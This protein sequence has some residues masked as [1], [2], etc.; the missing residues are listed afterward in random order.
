[1]SPDREIDLVLKA[2]LEDGPTGAPDRVLDALADRI[3]HESQRPGWRLHWRPTTM[4]P[5]FKV[6]VGIAAVLF[7]AIVGC[8]L[9]PASQ[10]GVGGPSA[11]P[12][13]TPT[14]SPT[15]TPIAM[16]DGP[17]AAGTYA[18]TLYSGPDSGGPFPKLVFTL[19]DG[20]TSSG[21]HITKEI[22]G[23]I[24]AHLIANAFQPTDEVYAHPCQWSSPARIQPGP[25]V[26]GLASALAAVPLRNATTP[27]DV[28]I[29][30]YHGKYL[31]WTVPNDIDFATCDKLDGEAV[32]QSWTG[33]NQQA[34]GQVDRLWILDIDGKRFV[35][36]AWFLQDTSTADRAEL[37]DIVNSIRFEP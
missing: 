18:L 17:L 2:W 20:W 26:D 35:L 16:V 25:T 31:E 30:G 32:F 29:G 4:Q 10:S 5:V 14:P 3:A 24:T 21:D 37:M 1:M 34:P 8:N 11:T 9:L 33:R 27:V 36:D 23:S 13:P 15:A 7:I 6:G 19:P 22:D 12:A 28:T